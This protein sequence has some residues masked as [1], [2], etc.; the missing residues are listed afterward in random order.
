MRRPS[1]LKISISG[2]R[3][4]IGRSFTPSL[5]LS[6]SEAFAT[7]LGGGKIAVATD[8]RPTRDLVKHAVFAGLLSCGAT[9]VDA[10]ILPIPSFQIY[11]KDTRARGGIA[12]TASHNP[13]EWNALKLVRRGGF[14][15]FSYQA[16]EILDIYHQGRF[17]RVPYFSSE[18][19]IDRD[20][21]RFHKRRLLRFADIEAIKKRRPKVVVDACN[22]AASPYVAEFLEALGCEVVAI[23][24]DVDSPFPHPPEPVPENLT[25]L[26]EAVKKYGAD[27]GFAQ[28]AD[29]DRLAA[30]DETGT[31]I[32]EEYTLA[33]AVKYYLE[34]KGKSPVVVNLSTSRAVEDVARE[35]GV[36]F[37]RAKVG[38]INVVEEMLRR[39]AKIGGE[40]NGGIIAAEVH[41]C[42]DSFSGMVLLLEFLS[43][44]GKT[45]SELA[46][47]LPRY[48][49]IKDKIEVS[50]KD[51]IRIVEHFKEA[52]HGGKLNLMDGIRIDYPDYWLHLR[53]SNTEPVLRLI[54]EA[55]SERTARE[56]FEKIREEILRLKEE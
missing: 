53:P 19:R 48:F 9:P 16:E 15:P 45:L 35:A 30:V 39:G 32:G 28:D 4:K 55:R 23:N 52:S 7:Y 3:G 44:S 24:T 46:S 51:G 49:M 36:S 14:F 2:I 29:A 18:P 26:S 34:N 8:T 33:L 10:G 31:P 5:V 1:D 42:R 12:I 43:K 50:M 11:V 17:K 38:E 56:I 54:V 6:F 47:E 22:G 27:I 20:A 13:V 37:F 21:F 41:P 25:Q 40:G